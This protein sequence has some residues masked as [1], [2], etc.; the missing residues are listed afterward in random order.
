MLIWCKN[1]I[2]KREKIQSNVHAT[3]RFVFLIRFFFY[4]KINLLEKISQILLIVFR[5][6]VV[7]NCFSCF[8]HKLAL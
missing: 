6:F 1:K 5:E 3:A 2:K 7:R 4:L 8:K